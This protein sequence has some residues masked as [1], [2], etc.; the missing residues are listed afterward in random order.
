VPWRLIYRVSEN[1]VY[2]LSVL[3][4]RQNVEGMLL[5]RLTG[6]KLLVCQQIKSADRYAPAD[7]YVGR[8]AARVGLQSL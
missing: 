5:R 4:F 8:R 3:N 1:K 6:L 7:F 2:V